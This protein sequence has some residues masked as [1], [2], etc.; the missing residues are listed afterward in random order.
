MKPVLQ[1]VGRLFC[2]IRML[3]T[4]STYTL[5]ILELIHDFSNLKQLHHMRWLHIVTKNNNL[6]NY[7]FA[8]LIYCSLYYNNMIV[9][10]NQS[11]HVHRSE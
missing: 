7:Y 10:T 11:I 3:Y 8:K 2:E 1:A 4:T 6:P 9:I 5:Q